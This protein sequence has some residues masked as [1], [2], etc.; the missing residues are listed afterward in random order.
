MGKDKKSKKSK[1]TSVRAVI[2]ALDL[3]NPAAAESQANQ[4]LE[5]LNEQN[6][7]LHSTLS[8]G[9]TTAMFVFECKQKKK[10]K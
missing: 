5:V 9:A 4:R 2:V 8:F 6:C 3:A 1:Y 7:T 10:D